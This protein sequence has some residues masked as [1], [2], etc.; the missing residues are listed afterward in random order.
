M[1]V[2]AAPNPQPTLPSTRT[3]RRQGHCDRRL[4]RQLKLTRQDARPA[5]RSRRCSAWSWVSQSQSAGELLRC[6]GRRTLTRAP[7]S[8]RFLQTAARTAPTSTHSRIGSA[9]RTR[10]GSRCSATGVKLQLPSSTRNGPSTRCMW[11]LRPGSR[12][13]RVVNSV[14]SGPRRTARRATICC[15]PTLEHLRVGAAGDELADSARR[16]R[17]ARYSSSGA[18]PP[19]PIASVSHRSSVA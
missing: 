2:A 8:R 15:S 13:L 6:S 5:Y 11:T 9:A 12:R 10:C 17:P 19:A 16:P 18:A 7:A 1:P 3:R 14:R 4:I